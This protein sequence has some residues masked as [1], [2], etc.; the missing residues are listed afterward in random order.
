MPAAKKQ[1]TNN[2]SV[3][4]TSST[5]TQITEWH[6]A[7]EI[8]N[9][10]SMPK[11][12]SEPLKALYQIEKQH[13]LNSQLTIAFT[14]LFTQLTEPNG[15][16]VANY[17]QALDEL[18]QNV[19]LNLD[20]SCRHLAQVFYMQKLTYY[21]NINAHSRDLLEAQR[22]YVIMM[23]AYSAY[24][25]NPAE[26]KD[27]IDA[28][29]KKSWEIALA[30]HIQYMQEFL[31]NK[32]IHKYFKKLEAHETKLKIQAFPKEA[33]NNLKKLVLIV[34]YLF[35]KGK[36]NLS[37]RWSILG[38]GSIITAFTVSALLGDGLI[39]AYSAKVSTFLKLLLITSSGAVGGA[40][41]LAIADLV[42]AKH[43]VYAKMQEL[44]D[45]LSPV[46][47]LNLY[48][49]DKNW[50]H[51][52][53]NSLSI[54]GLFPDTA[55]AISTQVN[56]R[57]DQLLNHATNKLHIT[58][59]NPFAIH[60]ATQAAIKS[61]TNFVII[62]G[63]ISTFALFAA[64]FSGSILMF[65][66]APTL[67]L[68][69]IGSLAVYSAKMSC[70]DPNSTRTKTIDFIISVICAPL[71]SLE[72]LMHIRTLYNNYKAKQSLKKH[73]NAMVD[74]TKKVLTTINDK[75]PLIAQVDIFIEQKKDQIRKAIAQISI[76]DGANPAHIQALKDSCDAITELVQAFATVTNP[77][78]ATEERAAA[79]EQTTAF[80]RAC[81]K[82]ERKEFVELAKQRQ[83]TFKESAGL[84]ATEQR[85]ELHTE[86]AL[87]IPGLRNYI[88][89]CKKL[90]IPGEIKQ[91]IEKIT[92]A[93]PRARNS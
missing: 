81:Y 42:T 82:I 65:A 23:R 8:L 93:A 46:D 72:G 38:A 59:G 45:A 69:V 76:L 26:L 50:H 63:M 48:V 33:K 88:Q 78:A 56:T 22:A 75:H 29:E 67:G 15:Q 7:L 30:C 43:K 85:V 55:H 31:A 62:G 2:I 80:L 28:Y 92:A 17:T 73:F 91:E 71:R 3:L 49:Q 9:N 47:L 10:G 89:E 86:P 12:L 13:N 77:D 66:L 87:L 68:S 21:N 57:I 6:M 70:D 37:T 14:N 1:K 39:S 36:I 83:Q 74:E 4:R 84:V 60:S 34:A 19:L 41:S 20:T 24:L 58:V 64:G 51:D 18:V 54:T 90:K 11:D 32:L 25:N 5:S 44:K 16:K 79:N 61:F 40:V 53:F 27:N 35:S 52:N